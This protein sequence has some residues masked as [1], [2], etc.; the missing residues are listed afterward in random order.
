MSAVGKRKVLDGTLIGIH[1][2]S[3]IALG[4]TRS[5]AW[6]SARSFFAI[7]RTSLSLIISIL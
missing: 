6:L 3:D 7:L 4:L 2:E 5:R 1:K